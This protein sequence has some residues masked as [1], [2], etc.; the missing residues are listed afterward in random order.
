MHQVDR[1]TALLAETDG[2][3]H[4]RR[5][6]FNPFGRQ[7]LRAA[8]RLALA[9][10]RC[11]QLV[12]DHHRRAQ[13]LDAAAAA[14]RHA[15]GFID[16]VI[17]HRL[18]LAGG[19]GCALLATGRGRRVGAI[20][21]RGR[22]HWRLV[23]GGAGHA[24]GR[25]RTGRAGALDHLLAAHRAGVLPQV[26]AVLLRRGFG[27]AEI[28]FGRDLC[29]DVVAPHH[30]LQNVQDAA[31]VLRLQQLHILQLLRIEGATTRAVGRVRQ[32]LAAV[33]QHAHGRQ[34]Q[35]GHA[36][37]HQVHDAGQLRAVERAAG[38]Q[39]HQD[40]CR[41]LL[42]LAKKTVLVGQCQM[43]ARG[44]HRRQRLDGAR[45]F[46]L[47]PALEVQPLLKLRHAELALLHQLE[48]GHRALG[49]ALRGQPQAHVVHLVGRHQNGA[50]AI[51][52]LVRHVHLR[53]LRHDGA[54]VLVAQVGK[55]HLVIGLAS[56]HQRGQGGCHQQ[57]QA[58]AQTHALRTA[59]RSHA[60]QPGRA[61]R[62][63]DSLQGDFDNCGHRAFHRGRATARRT[64][65]KA[66]RAGVR[67]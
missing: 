18:A 63:W 29:L 60:L 65:E 53:Q 20:D 27:L 8:A 49:Q 21:G 42:L 64:R 26:R 38:V 7:R 57:H 44:L 56:Q 5:H 13:A 16:F 55:Q 61:H 9:L 45:Q 66:A 12:I 33:V 35:L 28:D 1:V 59:E 39:A 6:L 36:R 54:A 51:G 46:A 11:R 52:V 50:A 41:R 3:A 22:R 48:P 43:H 47:Q 37:R 24:A 58:S 4:Q 67:S 34:C 25:L 2:L 31:R 10:C 30:R 32:Q 15:H 23:A 19:G 17:G 14:A 62:E 40:R